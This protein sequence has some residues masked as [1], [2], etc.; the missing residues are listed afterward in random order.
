MKTYNIKH[1]IPCYWD[2]D[3][4]KPMHKMVHI[5]LHNEWDAPSIELFGWLEM[6]D[7][8]GGFY[9]INKESFRISPIKENWIL[10]MRGMIKAT[11]DAGLWN[12]VI[13]LE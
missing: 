3:S 6:T 10:L 12:E 7:F 8:V 2:I 4:E 13:D 5:E 1:Y 9:D 11:K